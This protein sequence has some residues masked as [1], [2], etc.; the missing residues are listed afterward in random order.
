ME[1]HGLRL[2]VHPQV[3]AQRAHATPVL[4]KRFRPAALA[5]I[6]ADE[7]AVHD[8]LGAIETEQA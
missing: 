8:L 5:G 1:A 2:G 3:F 7:R 6:E 4:A